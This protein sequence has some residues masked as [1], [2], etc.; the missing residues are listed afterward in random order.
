LLHGDCNGVTNIPLE[1]AAEV[2][3]VAEEFVAAE[4]HVLDYVKGSG[5]KSLSE[6]AVRRKAMGNAIATL[7]RRLSRAQTAL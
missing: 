5:Q 3:D 2:A 4:V 6:L 1:I 7:R